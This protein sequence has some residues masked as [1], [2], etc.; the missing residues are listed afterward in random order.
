MRTYSFDANAVFSDNSAAY[1]ASGY[2]QALGADGLIDFGGN[3]GATVT[4]P[5]IA[6][7]VT[8]TPQQPRIDAMLVVDVTAIDISSGNETYQLDLMVSND[9]AFAAGNAVCAA[10]IQLGKGTS[11]RGAV[12]QKDSVTG[13]VEL[14]FT[15]Q[16]S[17]NIY[18]FAKLFLTLGGTTPSINIGA[19]VSV[20]PE[21]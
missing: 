17:G 9:P 11:L 21:P 1:V 7:V 3:Q 15:N 6:D 16:V 2:A 5:S 8:Q 14:G 19:F 20:T 18:Q 13:R 4:L 10:G 12:A